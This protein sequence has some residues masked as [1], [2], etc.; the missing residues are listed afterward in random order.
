MEWKTPERAT[1]GQ[2]RERLKFAW[3]PEECADGKTRWLCYIRVVEEL[4]A[5]F[6]G[7]TPEEKWVRRRTYRAE[8]E[9]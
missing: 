6:D 7:L 5:V 3:L 2:S 4:V 1:P 8:V 9:I